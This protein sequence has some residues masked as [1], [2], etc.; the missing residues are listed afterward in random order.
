MKTGL[1]VLALLGAAGTASAANVGDIIYTD[2]THNDIALVPGLGGAVTTLIDFPGAGGSLGNRAAGI[3]QVGTKFYVANGPFPVA[4]PSDS[5]ILE[6]DGLLSGTP[7]ISNWAFSD[8]IQNPTDIEYDSASDSLIWIQNP[9]APVAQGKKDGIFARRFSGGPVVESFTEPATS[10]ATPRYEAGTYMTKNPIGGG[11]YNVALNGGFLSGGP[12]PAGDNVSPSTLWKTSV[13][14]VTLAATL[15]LVLDFG[16]L[17]TDLTQVRGITAIPGVSALFVTEWLEG[18]VYRIDLDGSGGYA[19]ISLIASGFDHPEAIEYNPFT[20]KLVISEEANKN[21][22]TQKISQINP[23]GSGYQ[24]L[25]AQT[26]ARG[27]TF[28][29]PTPGAAGLAGF[30]GLIALRRRRA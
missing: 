1:V 15:S 7:T 29:V 6:I 24:V 28:V 27:F 9:S 18:N 11:Y 22:A 10:G 23:D 4:N 3:V 21:V 5:A 2:N 19:G 8:P 17:P 25:V 26:H 14:P 13:D 20:N 12:N 30:A 16:T